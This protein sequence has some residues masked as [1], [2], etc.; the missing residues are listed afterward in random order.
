MIGI[1]I[2]IEFAAA[3]ERLRNAGK[4]LTEKQLR[5]AVSHGINRTVMQARTIARKEVKR[6]YTVAQRALDGRVDIDKSTTYHKKGK[7]LK[8]TYLTAGVIASPKPVPMEF[9]KV[10]FNP[11]PTTTTTFTKRGLKKTSTRKSK[12]KTF[13]RGV[14]IEAVRGDKQ[15]IPFAFM[16]PTATVKV[17]ARGKYRAGGNQWGFVRRHKRLTNANGNDSVKPML[18]VTIHAAAINKKVQKT[19]GDKVE[20]VF[21]KNVEHEIDVI[22]A[23]I[24]K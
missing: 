21:M 10:Q 9:F 16:L 11:T 12:S 22:A 4:E 20:N 13:G 2:N 23:G 6:V 14:T 18:S 17:F 15:N 5:T 8:D 1:G 3:A 24:V 7:V 19:M